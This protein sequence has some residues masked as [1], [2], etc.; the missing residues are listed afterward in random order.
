MFTTKESA[1][2]SRDTVTVRQYAVTENRREVTAKVEVS[3]F[4]FSSRTENPT[5]ITL[6]DPPAGARTA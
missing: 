1:L 4:Y 2:N 3:G 5:S 6:T